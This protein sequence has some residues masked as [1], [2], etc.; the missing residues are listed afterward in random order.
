MINFRNEMR[1]EAARKFAVF[2]PILALCQCI[3]VEARIKK[4]AGFTV[5][6]FVKHTSKVNWSSGVELYKIARGSR[7]L[8]GALCFLGGAVRHGGAT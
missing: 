5:P 8:E 2:M 7:H 3:A 4:T 6:K 1:R